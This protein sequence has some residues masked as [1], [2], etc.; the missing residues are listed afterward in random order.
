M[1]TTPTPELVGCPVTRAVVLDSATRISG[2][3]RAALAM[4]CFCLRHSEPV[5]VVDTFPHSLGL[6]R[7]AAAVAPLLLFLQVLALVQLAAAATAATLELA[8]ARPACPPGAGRGR[9]AGSGGLPRPSTSCLT[10]EEVSFAGLG[11]W[12]TTLLDYSTSRRARM[13][14]DARDARLARATA[15]RGVL[16]LELRQ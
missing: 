14:R 11:M 12:I 3:F 16:Q 10:L 2:C 15:R 13:T 6:S 5:D 8:R 1:T 7:P 4:R 9:R